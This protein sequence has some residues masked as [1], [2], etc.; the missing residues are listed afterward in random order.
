MSSAQ[1]FVVMIRHWIF[2]NLITAASSLLQ[3]PVSLSGVEVL[4]SMAERPAQSVPSRPDWDQQ[5]YKKYLVK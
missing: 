5:L 2:L 4:S 1:G 3:R